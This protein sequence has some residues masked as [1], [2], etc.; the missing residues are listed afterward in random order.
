MIL[1]DQTTTVNTLSRVKMEK[2]VNETDKRHQRMAQRLRERYQVDK[3]STDI[4]LQKPDL[5]RCSFLQWR[6]CCKQK[7]QQKS[8]TLPAPRDQ[9]YFYHVRLGFRGH[10]ALWKASHA[11]EVLE[12]IE[13]SRSRGDGGWGVRG[14]RGREHMPGKQCHHQH[15]SLCW[16]GQVGSRAHQ[17]RSTHTATFVSTVHCSSEAETFLF[18]VA[19]KKTYSLKICPLSSCFTFKAPIHFGTQFNDPISC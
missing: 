12:R 17:T 3:S 2:E 15:Y 16:D 8:R 19:L 6:C 4:K 13:I 18:V 11:H 14:V 5:E 10:F 7:Q 9:L 1:T